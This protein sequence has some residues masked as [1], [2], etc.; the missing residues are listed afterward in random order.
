MQ[1]KHGELNDGSLP[2]LN[3]PVIFLERAG[4]FEDQI[5]YISR[6]YLVS[7]AHHEIHVGEF[8]ELWDDMAFIGAPSLVVWIVLYEQLSINNC[9]T[10]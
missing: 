8:T 1:H 9:E 5:Q 10:L 7:V 4:L 3:V 6:V 2:R